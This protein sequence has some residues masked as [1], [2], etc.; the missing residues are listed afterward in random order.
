V[1]ENHSRWRQTLAKTSVTTNVRHARR[2]SFGCGRRTHFPRPTSTLTRAF[3][4]S[5]GRPGAGTPSDPRGS[6]GC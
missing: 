3:A 1:V 6:C 5:S 4:S 2:N